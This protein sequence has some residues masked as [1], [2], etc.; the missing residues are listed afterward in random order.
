MKTAIFAS[1]LASAA[2]FAPQQAAKSTSALRESPFANEIGAQAPLG[3]WDPMNFLEGYTK[4]DFD[5]LRFKELKH[6][7]IAMLAF[8]YVHR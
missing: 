8:L 7:R 6:G 5:E 4:E 3:F 2:A 1:L